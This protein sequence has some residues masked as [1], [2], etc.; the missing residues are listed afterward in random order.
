MIWGTNLEFSTDYKAKSATHF[1]NSTWD[2][3]EAWRCRI[4]AGKRDH[5]ELINL[6]TIEKRLSASLEECLLSRKLNRQTVIYLNGLTFFSVTNCGSNVTSVST[7]ITMF[8][9]AH[10]LLLPWKCVRTWHTEQ[11]SNLNNYTTLSTLLQVLNWRLPPR[12]CINSQFINQGRTKSIS[13]PALS[14]NQLSTESWLPKGSNE[15]LS[16]LPSQPR[17]WINVLD[18]HGTWWIFYCWHFCLW[19]FSVNNSTVY[20]P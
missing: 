3:V 19:V 18:L 14:F 13:K 7:S 6:N 20:N 1:P 4:N 5:L 11:G 2:Q 16:E 12:R 15:I 17:L 9:R 8:V 10:S